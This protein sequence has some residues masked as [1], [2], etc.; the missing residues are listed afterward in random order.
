MRYYV[1]AYDKNDNQIFGNLDGQGVI[2]AQDFRR[3]KHYKSLSTRKTLNNR[4]AYYK[5][6]SGDT[7]FDVV[8]N[9]A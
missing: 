8:Q 1:E 3:T 2:V 9:Q 7:T 6:T 5:I 4:V